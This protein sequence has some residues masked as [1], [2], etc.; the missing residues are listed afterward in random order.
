[1]TCIV[2]FVVNNMWQEF[3]LNLHGIKHICDL[4]KYLVHKLNSYD[5]RSIFSIFTYKILTC[6]CVS[7]WKVGFGVECC[8]KAR[9]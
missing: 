9:T 2:I 1:M 4:C 3:K 7:I 6:L 8:N 5:L